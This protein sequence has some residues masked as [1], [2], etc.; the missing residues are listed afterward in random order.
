MKKE[1]EIVVPKSW[2]AVTLKDYLELHK[3]LKA[4]EDSEEAMTAVMFHKLCK[5]KVE[6]ISKLD[7]K[8]YISIKNQLSSFLS[9]T[10][11]PLQRY[12]NIDGIEYGFEPNLSNMSYGAYV[13]ITKYNELTIN[14]KWA[15]IMSILYRPVISKNAGFYDIKQYDGNVNPTPF[16]SVGMDVHFGA[17]F[18]LQNL[19]KDLLKSTLN[20]MMETVEM[21]ANIKSILQRSGVHIPQ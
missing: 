16:L 21:P 9:N 6:W 20:Y 3:D 13:D 8:T 7:I 10:E 11:L 4:Y 1:I 14:D 19:Y 12:I 15:E 17:L 5:L 18:F 2:S